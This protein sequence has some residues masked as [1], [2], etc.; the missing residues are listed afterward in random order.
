MSK[1]Y[2]QVYRE[3]NTAKFSTTLTHTPILVLLELLELA[4]KN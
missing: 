4:A 3:N 1:G 2:S